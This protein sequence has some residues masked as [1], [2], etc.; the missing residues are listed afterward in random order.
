MPEISEGREF[1]PSEVELLWFV[2]RHISLVSPF[3]YLCSTIDQ[4][5]KLRCKIRKHHGSS[6]LRF[7]QKFTPAAQVLFLS[8]KKID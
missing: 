8:S 4:T 7:S 6:G 5:R 2:K 1:P 3:I